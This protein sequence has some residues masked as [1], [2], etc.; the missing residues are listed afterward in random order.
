MAKDHDDDIRNLADALRQHA[1]SRPDS[2][3]LIDGERRIDYRELDTLVDCAAQALL[4]RMPSR[5]H[6]RT[7]DAETTGPMS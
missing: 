2:A 3:A 7:V 1:R 5:R 6:G 4:A